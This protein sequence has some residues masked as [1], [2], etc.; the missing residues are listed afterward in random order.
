MGVQTNTSEVKDTSINI[1]N[2]KDAGN[3]FTADTLNFNAL[4]SG[5]T[6]AHTNGQAYLGLNAVVA[7]GLAN[8]A[9]NANIKIDD[10]NTFANKTANITAQIGEDGKYTAESTGFAING[11]AVGVNINDM[12]AKTA[13]TA[14]VNIGNEYFSDDTTLNVNALNKASRNSF[15]RNNAYSLVANAN[16]ISAYT[17][18]NDAATIT[19]GKNSTLENANKL[20]A[21]NITADTENKSYV[22]AKGTGGS[23]GGDFGSAAHADN[24]ANNTNLVNH[25]TDDLKLSAQTT[26]NDIDVNVTGGIFENKN[27]AGNV[28]MDKKCGGER[29]SYQLKK[30]ETE[31]RSLNYKNPS[32]DCRADC[33]RV[34]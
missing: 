16:D 14:Q 4:N 7:K 28:N 1:I 20:G 25:R 10:E 11:S 5:Q 31:N 8:S 9:T 26:N 15:M 21:L 6:Y 29:M 34:F 13:S 22:A 18:A 27:L 32:A 30:S 23:I 33:R 17:I 19:V 24:D 2:V 3:T 12:I